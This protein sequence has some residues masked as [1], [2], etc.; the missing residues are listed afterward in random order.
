MNIGENFLN[1]IRAPRGEKKIFFKQSK[2]EMVY[3]RNI[4]TS[5]HQKIYQYI[6]TT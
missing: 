4:R 1:K 3:P 5:E 2:V 6:F